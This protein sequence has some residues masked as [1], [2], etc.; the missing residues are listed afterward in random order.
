MGLRK[1]VYQ[2]VRDAVTNIQKKLP[3]SYK[4]GSC[5]TYC[6]AYKCSYDVEYCTKVIDSML[7][8]PGD[9]YQRFLPEGWEIPPGLETA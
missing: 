7:D 2:D 9:R 4:L 6:R 1:L 3:I 5:K 8:E